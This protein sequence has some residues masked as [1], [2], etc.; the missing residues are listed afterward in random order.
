[1]GCILGFGGVLYFVW[2]T[3]D[4]KYI[5]ASRTQDFLAR[6]IQD[7]CLNERSNDLEG[8]EVWAMKTLE[9]ST[10]SQHPLQCANQPWWCDSS[11]S[12]KTMEHH[13][14]CG[15]VALCEGQ[16]LYTPTPHPRK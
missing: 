10:G 8:E 2:G 15:E 9:E 4:R 3:Y 12:S 7:P 6:P 13:D 5:Q 14:W 16:I 11:W 1:M